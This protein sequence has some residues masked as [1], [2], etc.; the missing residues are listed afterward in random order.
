MGE[1][2]SERVAEAIRKEISEIIQRELKD[3]RIGFITITRV[4]VTNDLR[5]AL[6]YFSILGSQDD[7]KKTLE[8]LKSS[9]GFLRGQIGQRLRLR[10]TP[11]LR[12]KF[13]GSIEHSAHIAEVLE[14]LKK[15]KE[16]NTRHSNHDEQI[17]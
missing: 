2:R 8:G 4:Q 1:Q 7:R 16:S 10:F 12:F 14:K 15:E 3:P 11:E 13:D 5:S 17:E 9:A 6:V